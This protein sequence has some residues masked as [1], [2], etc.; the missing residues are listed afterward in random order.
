MEEFRE[1]EMSDSIVESIP[2]SGMEL[3]E[4][5]DIIRTKQYFSPQSVVHMLL[6]LQTHLINK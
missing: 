2:R 6:P 1:S 3:T 5:A 4:S